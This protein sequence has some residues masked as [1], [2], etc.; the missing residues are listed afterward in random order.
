MKLYPNS[1]TLRTMKVRPAPPAAPHAI[2]RSDRALLAHRQ[3]ASRRRSV[4]SACARTFTNPQTAD[5]IRLIDPLAD[6]NQPASTPRGHHRAMGRRSSIAAFWACA[7]RAV[8]AG[9]RAAGRAR[10]PVGCAGCSVA[11]SMRARRDAHAQV[12]KQLRVGVSG[13]SFVCVCVCVR[14]VEPDV[15]V[16][17]SLDVR[18][19]I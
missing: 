5:G 14:D 8:D 16:S 4:R 11:L 18:A 15:A 19:C 6:L 12:R 10:H 17:F 1:T 2:D 7:A 13:R 3:T 9:R